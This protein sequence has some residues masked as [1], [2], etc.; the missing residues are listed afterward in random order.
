MTIQNAIRSHLDATGQSM[1]ALSLKAGL[2]PKAISDILNRPGIRPN[3]G[4]IDALNRAMGT[5]LPDPGRVT[6]YASLMATL[7]TKT[8][9][10]VIDRRNARLVSRLKTVIRAADWVPEIE[11]VDRRRILQRFAGWSPASLGLS[12]ESFA[13]YK[14]D[15]LAAIDAGCGANRKPG[16]RDVSGLYR[17]VYDAVQ[18]TKWAKDLK[19]VSG[20]FFFFLDREGILPSEITPTILEDYYRHRLADSTKT[21][22]VCRKHVKRIAAL[23]VRLSSDPAFTRFGFPNVA[24]P[25]EDGRDKYGVPDSVLADLLREFDGPVTRWARGEE[26]RSGLTYADFLEQMDAQERTLHVDDKKALLPSRRSGRKA[27]DKDRRSAGF[28][29]A[30]ETWSPTTLLNRRGILVAGAKALYAASGYLI[31]SIAEYTDPDVAESVLD[32]VKVGNADGEFPSSYAA[33]IGKTLKKLARDYVGRDEQDVLTV[34]SIIKDHASGEKGI[35]KRNKAKLREI[36]GGRQQRLIDLG[37]IL[38]DEVNTELD[39]RARRAR[40]TA[41]TDLI[42]AELARDVMC[43]LASDILLARA[44]RKENLLGA[45]LS[46]ISWRDDL[47]TIRVPNVEVKMRGEDDPDLVIPLGPNESR[48]LR[49]YLDKIRPKALMEGD[50]ANPFLFPAQ[51]PTVGPGAPFVGLI[52]RLMRHTRRIV[53]IRMNPHLYRHFVGWL[54]LKEDPDRL[55]D[56]Q[57]LLGH[58]S[59]ETT[60][61]HYAEIDEGLALDRWQKFLT[62]KKSRQPKGFKKKGSN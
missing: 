21:D 49:Q 18:A 56:V 5:E 7:S 47:A 46:W 59:L 42:D 1:Q 37:E 45:L 50:E 62:D 11:N 54:W 9:D 16:M 39:R 22:A 48:R 14:A 29:L 30:D 23:C 61:Q 25:F 19:L 41:R 33:T 26:S 53:G 20:S 35:A 24:H 3:R 44:P 2:N 55:P 8:G 38:I 28:L 4:T 12:P 57:R 40:G 17:E 36:V 52:E 34:A 10:E 13:T 6:T 31:K 27:T 58:K 51:G 15:V 60:L 43:A 32:S